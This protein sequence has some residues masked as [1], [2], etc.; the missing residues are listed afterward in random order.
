MVTK[1]QEETFCIVVISHFFYTFGLYP[2]SN[3]CALNDQN[4]FHSAIDA[5]PGVP[6]VLIWDK[7]TKVHS[8]E[9][10]C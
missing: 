9:L 6:G 5:P 4:L 2:Y 8:V 1:I 7:P 10:E 3:H